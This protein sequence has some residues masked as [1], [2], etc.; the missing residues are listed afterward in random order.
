MVTRTRVLSE[1]DRR[2]NR[3]FLSIYLKAVVE[4]D[5]NTAEHTYTCKSLGREARWLKYKGRRL[6]EVVIVLRILLIR[7]EDLAHAFAEQHVRFV[8]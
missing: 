3:R 2:P 1:E 4:H 6:L 8:D 5:K 7:L